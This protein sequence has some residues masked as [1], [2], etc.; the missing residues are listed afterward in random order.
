MMLL[1]INDSANASVWRHDNHLPIWILKSEK[2]LGV[3]Y[4]IVCKKNKSKRVNYYSGKGWIF[5]MDH[6]TSKSSILW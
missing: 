1:S 2:E 6:I 3:S 5:N 4:S